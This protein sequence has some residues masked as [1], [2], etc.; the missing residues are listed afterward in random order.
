[1]QWYGGKVIKEKSFQV[2]LQI[3]GIGTTT[4]KYDLKNIH[5]LKKLNLAN[6]YFTKS[7]YP[8]CASLPIEDYSNIR[9]IMLL[10]LDNA[11]LGT[12]SAI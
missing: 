2:G 8:E 3:E 7:K 9:P 12:P 5:T 1:M 11:F 10:G 4:P 6:Q